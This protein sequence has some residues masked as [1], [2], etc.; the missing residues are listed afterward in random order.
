MATYYPLKLL[1]TGPEQDFYEQKRICTEISLNLMM[2]LFN[3]CTVSH[4]LVNNFSIL[5]YALFSNSIVVTKR[6]KGLPKELED[7]VKNHWVSFAKQM[8]RFVSAWG[9][10]V[11]DYDLVRRIPSAVCMP[12]ECITFGISFDGDTGEKE[13][14]A[15]MG[16]NHGPESTLFGPALGANSGAMP[17]DS[18]AYFRRRAFVIETH[19][20]HSNGNLGCN[21]QSLY[22]MDS[23]VTTLIA[24]CAAVAIRNVAPP[25]ITQKAESK[26]EVVDQLSGIAEVELGDRRVAHLERM[27]GDA[28]THEFAQRI[29][30]S[31]QFKEFHDDL[32]GTDSNGKSLTKVDPLTN[33]EAYGTLPFASLF[34]T[35]SQVP[36]GRVYV[37]HAPLGQVCPFLM[38]LVNLQTQA[39]SVV[40][41]IPQAM[42]GGSNT[43]G[44][45]MAD[46]VAYDRSLRT[47]MDIMTRSLEIIAQ[48]VFGDWDED[49]LKEDVD[50]MLETK[51]SSKGNKNPTAKEIESILEN[52]IIRVR[53][54]QHITPHALMELYYSGVFEHGH[55]ID[56]L[57]KYYNIDRGEFA[58]EHVDPATG[59]PVSAARRV[60][61][62]EKV[63]MMKAQA[64]LKGDGGDGSGGGAS[65]ASAPESLMYT[66]EPVTKS[67]KRG[68]GQ[69]AGGVKPVVPTLPQSSFMGGEGSLG[70]LK[71]R[72]G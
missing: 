51:R 43:H 29:E 44:S 20:P 68:L 18:V 35:H 13:Y 61:F 57:G 45:Q 32:L 24:T 22:R 1:T 7:V 4:S 27:T 21:T 40:L 47:Y 31:Q 10:V 52:N 72:K 14:Y 63:A 67:S 42:A 5:E 25:I 12:S 15:V 64:S 50:E 19:A 11:V 17:G 9:F 56:K 16:R 66:S 28:E 8:L 55:V 69:S 23:F 33:T 37:G 6:K 60:D 2:R 54:E 34:K 49:T 59:I 65:S 46:Q 58:Q 30:I 53:I 36:A 71:R 70:D 39:C 41:G 38:D 3:M 62:E 48:I 26:A